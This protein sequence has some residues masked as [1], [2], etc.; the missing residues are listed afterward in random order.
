[1]S[2]TPDDL[3]DEARRLR[4]A[5]PAEA[6][7]RI[8]EISCLARAEND[9]AL[10]GRALAEL[11]RLDR[12]CGARESS[13]ARYEEAA[14]IARADGDT[15]A[16]A[17]RLRHA[18]DVRVEMGDPAGAAPALDEALAHYRGLADTAP[19]DLAN[20]L[21][22]AALHRELDGRP[23]EAAAFWSEAGR[24]YGAAGIEAGVAECRRHAG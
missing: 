14:E 3:F 22:S 18:G 4:S 7:L 13:V 17:H 10:L 5:H 8:E 16:L 9:R 23:A 6:R 15:E 12:D 2:A 20:M 11:G 19:L 21:R 24:L 1:M